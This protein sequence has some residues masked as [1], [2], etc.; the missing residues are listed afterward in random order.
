LLDQVIARILR[1]NVRNKLTPILGYANT[2]AEEAEDPI[3]QYA[4]KIGQNSKELERTTVHAREMREIV[5]GRDQMTTVSLGT[6]VRSAATSIEEKFPDCE[7]I[8]RIEGAV[9][10][11]A[12]PELGTAIR[13]LVRNG[14]EHNDSD[15]SRV[16]VIVEQG[17]DGPTVEI[18]DNG[19]GID[20]FE[21]EIIEE[22]GE[23]ALKHGSGVG[24]WIV[25]RVIEYSGA[26]IEF[27]TTDGTTAS[28]TFGTPAAN[29]AGQD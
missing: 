29:Q 12:H 21:V 15:T 18:S 14:F 25:D 4:Q 17:P 11:T 7:L 23:S 20:P 28:I 9:E 6:T 19:S 2:I 26:A 10:V 1:H 16:E 3:S 8:T 5:R 24:L 27:E 13:H 22:H